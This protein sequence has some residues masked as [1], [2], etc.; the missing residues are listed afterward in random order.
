MSNGKFGQT[1][2]IHIADIKCL[3][4]TTLP[5]GLNYSSPDPLNTTLS[6]RIYF[7]FSRV[8][9]TTRSFFCVLVAII[10]A[11]VDSEAFAILTIM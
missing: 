8:C 10:F 3:C 11:S 9:L 7:S 2:I 4:G 1:I 6:F 5:V